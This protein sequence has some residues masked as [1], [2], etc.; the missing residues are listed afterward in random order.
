MN[1]EHL[2]T[3]N[4][5]IFTIQKL[6]QE[7]HGRIKDLVLWKDEFRETKEMLN[8]MKTL[9]EEAFETGYDKDN[10]P[11]STICYDYK[12][13]DSDSPEPTLLSWR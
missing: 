11:M 7:R 12:I 9:K 4:T 5:H 2:F 8:S 3:S 13:V 6:L 10:A 1:F